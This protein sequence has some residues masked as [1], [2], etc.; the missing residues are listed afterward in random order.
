[1]KIWFC[2]IGETEPEN[3]R[4]GGDSP[5]RVAVA[6][7]YREITGKEPTFCFSGWAGQLTEPERAAVENRLPRGFD[8]PVNTAHPLFETIWQAIKDWDIERSRG[9]GYAGA[10][11]T[12][13]QTI[14]DAIEGASS[15]N[16]A[17]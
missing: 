6:Q 7:A 3:V 10:T 13:V 4:S 16:S 1:M 15:E 2:K 17:P 5:M 8:K 12:D 9:L 11:G 14:I